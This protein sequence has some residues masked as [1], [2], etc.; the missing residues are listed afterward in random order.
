MPGKPHSQEA[1]TAVIAQG[2]GEPESVDAELPPRTTRQ[3][4]ADWRTCQAILSANPDITCNADDMTPED[5]LPV[6]IQRIVREEVRDALA[7]VVGVI[8]SELRQVSESRQQGQ[9]VREM[10]RRGWRSD[11]EM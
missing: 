2:E 4:A 9:D 7:E 8:L 1:R 5:A 11:R 10:A 6:I 3:M